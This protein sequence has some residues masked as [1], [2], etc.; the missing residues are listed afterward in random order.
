MIKIRES[1]LIREG[2]YDKEHHRMTN[3]P[4]YKVWESI[5]KRCDY[6]K[7]DNYEIY[8]GRGIS[9]DER[10]IYFSNF[11]ADMG[12]KPSPKHRIDRIDNNGHYCKDNCRWVTPQ[13]N[14]ANRM[15]YSDCLGAYKKVG[16]RGIVYT[17]SIG[18]DNHVY[19]I[20]TF[21]TKEEAQQAYKTV[22]KEW[23]G[24]LPIEGEK[25]CL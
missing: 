6:R 13:V 23:Y 24:F 16:A 11:L 1:I 21:K 12:T 7:S 3:S 5:K 22:F 8:G 19:H 4:E 9:Y 14:A 10:W 20:G 2:S 17:S 15:R 25:K 18:I